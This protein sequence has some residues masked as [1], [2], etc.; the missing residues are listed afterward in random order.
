M[1]PC[2]DRNCENSVSLS[3]CTWIWSDRSVKSCHSPSLRMCEEF[4]NRQE[5]SLFNMSESAFK[6]GRTY[7]TGL[8]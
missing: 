8:T 3:V 2:L 1:M 6:S 5:S 7:D 4:F